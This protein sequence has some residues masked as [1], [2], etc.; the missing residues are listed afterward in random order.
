MHKDNIVTICICAFVIALALGAVS[1]VRS[2]P[3]VPRCQVARVNA[4]DG[5]E[6]RQ[7]QLDAEANIEHARN[8]SLASYQAA[9][10]MAQR[11]RTTWHA[12]HDQR[13]AIAM[14]AD[15]VMYCHEAK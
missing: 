8:L 3:N 12:R 1:A 2:M 14:H 6:F 7:I 5:R 15:S 9:V 10:D 11:A 4:E 13:I